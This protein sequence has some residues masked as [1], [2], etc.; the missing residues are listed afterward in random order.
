MRLH[1]P[2]RRIWRFTIYVISLVLVLIAADLILV[3]V[4]RSFTYGYDTTRIV[5]P[6]MPDGRID[7]MSVLDAQAAEGVT[8]ENNAAVPFLEAVGR[9]GLSPTQLPDGI[10]SKLGMPHLPEQGDYLVRYDD[11]VKQH[12]GMAA[13]GYPADLPTTWPVTIDPLA[14]Q[15]VKAN[16]HPL[17]LL[18][19]A[20]KRSRFF[21][22]FDGGN[23]PSVLASVLLPH[24]GLFRESGRLLLMRAMMRL[25]AGD[26][27]GFRED[28][29]AT[30]R[31][32]R[33][34]GQSPTAVERVQARES[35][36]IPA[37]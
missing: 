10:T 27:A 9:S 7:Y 35:L 18:I 33:L 31:L 16:E 21:I 15:W 12:D 26:I 28:L 36:E 3:Q 2:R 4:R 37:C 14:A 13:G 34:L 23:R 8:F 24:V 20:S 30:H 32:A 22:P 25:N 29:L 11:F 1:L 19:E 6:V 5:G 17:E